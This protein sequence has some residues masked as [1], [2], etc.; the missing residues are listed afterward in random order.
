MAIH[1]V[2]TNSYM[3]LTSIP[4]EN[5][6]FTLVIL[7]SAYFSVPVNGDSQHMFAFVWEGQQC[8]LDG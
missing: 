7:C 5:T 4:T 2:I 1:K 3:L 6:I 8:T